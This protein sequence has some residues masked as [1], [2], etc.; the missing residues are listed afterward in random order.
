LLGELSALYN[1][2]VSGAAP[3]LPDAIQIS[4]YEQWLTRS[5]ETKEW[6]LQRDFWINRMSGSSS[7]LELP[8]DH[9]RPPRK[10]YRG[11][12]LTA[13]LDPQ[14]Y[15]AIK[16]AG[17][18]ENCT[19]FMTLL[20]A[21]TVLLH[22]LADQREIVVGI[23][24]LGRSLPEADRLV[25]YCAHITPIRSDIHANSRFTEHLRAIRSALLDAFENQDFPFA[26]Y[27]SDLNIPRDPSRA[28]LVNYVF[29]LDGALPVPKM[30]GLTVAYYDQPTSTARFD[31]GLNGV[32]IDNRLVLYCDFNTD[33]FEPTTIQRLLDQ[34]T[35]LLKA[36]ADSPEQLVST[37][38]LLSPE[39]RRQLLVD[40]NHSAAPYSQ[41]SMAQLFEQ[42]VEASPNAVAVECQGQRMT[43]RELNR[44][45]NQLAHLLQQSGVGLEVT[46]GIC[47]ERS[48]E[49]IV[50]LLG[51]L[52]AGGAYVPL[53][54]DFP[55]QRIALLIS[56][57]AVVLILSEERLLAR[58][59]EKRPRTICLDNTA[60]LLRQYD[61]RNHPCRATIDHLAYVIYTSGSTG[62]PKGAAIPQ[63]A[64]VRLVR[65]SNFMDLGPNTVFLGYAPLSFDASTLEIW[66]PLLNGGRLV[67][68]P[69]QRLS[70]EELG[71]AIRDSGI[72]ALWL[73]AGLFRL[74]VDHRL[75]DF[76]NIRQLLAGGDVLSPS[77]VSRVLERW[78]S[79]TVI[80]GYGPTE[81]TTFTTCHRVTPRYR[82]GSSVP[83]GRPVSNTTVYILDLQM[84]PVPVGVP[85]ELYAGGHGL[86]RGYINNPELTRA[87]FVPNPF[88]ADPQSRLYKTGDRARYLPDGTI[89]FLGRFDTQ[90]KIRGF[91]IELGEVE[92]ALAS[93]PAI[94][95]A[96]VIDFEDGLDSK[97]LV[98]YFVTPVGAANPEVAALR[99]H[100]SRTLPDYMIPAAFVRLEVIPLTAH[101]KVDRRALP[102]PMIIGS[103]EDGY[104]A[105]RTATEEILAGIWSDV[106]HVERVGVDDNFFD[107]GGHSLLASQLLTRICQA[108]R[109]DLSL[110]QLFEA[111]TVAELARRLTA[112]E[113][114]P[115]Q[116]EKIAGLRRRV[117]GMSMAEMT[118]E[119][120]RHSTKRQAQREP[121]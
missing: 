110:T 108:F 43:Y 109:M 26:N 89:E 72:N 99:A 55:Q 80:N 86:A 78:P 5:I 54:P 53:S 82:F 59:P 118:R 65:G 57:A 91:R 9:P 36:V 76:Q 10:T 4:D 45:S 85:G 29:N 79:C 112:L 119:I 66:G 24:V 21:Y 114:T 20:A 105:P 37:V 64:V 98:A 103:G 7:A 3:A 23:P 73:T 46:V 1:A 44:R 16:R 39:Q 52:K 50:G 17:Q 94:R 48:P 87:R 61:D 63:R 77:H 81:N 67:L 68:M 42:Q 60:E 92:A 22:R 90:V 56:D 62:I 8:T 120:S 95:D 33:L 40:W 100:L 31:I 121:V 71:A 15:A 101:G 115:G 111:Q 27:L 116:V 69:P 117:Q 35:I 74:L 102:A 96:V 83:I 28:P 84:Q 58:L 75:E 2:A 19:M 25:A 113:G 32:E 104:V 47:M 88:S 97:S 12:R 6:Q 70:H 14:L 18:R 30:E 49:M 93:Y 11:K 51:I 34:F 106:L 41:V 38:P 107:L 13:S